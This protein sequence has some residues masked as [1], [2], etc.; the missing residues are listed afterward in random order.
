MQME[1]KQHKY[2]P[3]GNCGKG[4]C[5]ICIKNYAFSKFNIINKDFIS[6]AIAPFVG[7]FGY[8]NINLGILAP[9]EQKEDSWLLDAPKYWSE[10][11]YGITEIV[12]FRSSLLNSRSNINLKKRIKFLDTVQEITMSSKPIDVE[13]QLEEKPKF[14]LNLDAYIAPT[15]PNAKLK[16]ASITGNPKIHTKVYKVFEDTDLKAQEAINYLYSNNFDENFLSKLL[17]VGTLGIKTNRKLV[18]TRFS[19]TAVDDTIGKE[20]IAQVK[21]YPTYNYLAYF[22]GYLGNYYLLLMFPEV[23]SHELF[24]T[25]IPNNCNQ[26]LSLKYST[27]YECYYGRKDYAKDTVGGYY[28]SRLAI[29]E[30]LKKLKR[31]AT[32]LSLRFITDD[33]TVPLGVW[34]VREA[35]RKALAN[36]PIEF[37]SKEL[38]LNY[39]KLLIKRKFNYNLDN[40]IKDSIILKNINMQSKL[41]EFII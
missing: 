28:S 17:S 23:W 26:N 5:L 33:Y 34:V 30:Q 29:L 20:L 25:Y 9:P 32:V 16:K 10:K 3:S 14:K 2:D 39:A 1:Y 24:E 40:I 27:D 36:K 7:R 22:G 15:G 12:D 4:K 41:T 11:E 38:M 19:I 31:Q 8:P 35:T 6:D 21:N 18:P 37:S 13:I